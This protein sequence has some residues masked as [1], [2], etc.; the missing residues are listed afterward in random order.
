MA[1][2]FCPPPV[3]LAGETDDD[4]TEVGTDDFSGSGP[5][6]VVEEIAVGE[7]APETKPEGEP[8]PEGEP[9]P[10]PGR[11]MRRV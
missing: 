11:R 1:L 10:A 8:E 5:A 4:D 7:P 3:A 2:T 6:A 9:A